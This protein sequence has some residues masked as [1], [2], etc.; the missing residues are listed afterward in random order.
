MCITSEQIDPLTK[1]DFISFCVE[2]IPTIQGNFAIRSD[3]LNYKES[4]FN[5]I[6][7]NKVY[8]VLENN[9]KFLKIIDLSNCKLYRLLKSDLALIKKLY[10]KTV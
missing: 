5:Y 3:E 7:Y 1:N 2:N 8:C 4:T 9:M 6:E 10:I